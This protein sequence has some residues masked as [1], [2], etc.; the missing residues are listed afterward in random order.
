MTGLATPAPPKKSTSKNKT[1]S[2][3][4]WKNLL[5]CLFNL[6]ILSPLATNKKKKVHAACPKF[7]NGNTNQYKDWQ[8]DVDIYVTA[9]ASDM[10]SDE[11]K[12]LFVLSYLKGS[13]ADKYKQNWLDA[14]RDSDINEILINDFFCLFMRELDRAFASVNKYEDT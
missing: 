10:D 4:E 8:R 2:Q 14:Q 11:N 3:D 6:E 12:I 5:S 1:V 13:A 7:F 9:A